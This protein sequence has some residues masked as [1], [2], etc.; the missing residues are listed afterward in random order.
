MQ[1]P[2]SGL[3]PRAIGW[4]LLSQTIWLPLVGIDLHDRWQARVKELTPPGQA[5]P[6]LASMPGGKLLNLDDLLRSPLAQKMREASE[7]S[8]GILL[9]SASRIGSSLLDRPLEQ[10]LEASA[11][12]GRPGRGLAAASASVS[13]PPPGPLALLQRQVSRA[14]L[15]GG[16]LELS[17]L[18]EGPMSALAMVERARRSLSD[19]PMAAL[20]AAWR[21]PMRQALQQL[22]GA[23][24]RIAPAR[25]VHV[26]SSRVKR[27][28]E[29]PLAMQCDG[30]VDI[31]ST[32]DGPEVVQEIDNWS[33]QQRA[34]QAGSI[35]PAV[36]HLHPLDEVP[37]H[38]PSAGLTTAPVAAASV[39]SSATPS[40]MQAP[41]QVAPDAMAPEA[42]APEPVAAEAPQASAMAEPAAMAPA[43]ADAPAVIEVPAATAL[44]TP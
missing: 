2:N 18:Q 5:V 30:S 13:A 28:T 8:T 33:R 43:A 32:P 1:P 3:N 23:A 26:A 9:G 7:T 19:D 4:A 25:V 34:P 41:E 17:D 44:P 11:V 27:I 16:R 39:R 12:T 22:P 24:A 37:V 38:A 40:A 14:E 29:V 31:L 35:A 10:S 21:A 42:M 6:K 36:V 20:P 15:L